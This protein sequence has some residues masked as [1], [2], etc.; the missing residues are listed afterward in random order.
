MKEEEEEKLSTRGGDG[1]RKK[2]RQGYI[3]RTGRW[4]L[5]G[6]TILKAGQKDESN[7]FLLWYELSMI[8]GVDGRCR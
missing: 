7:D 8:L 2:T 1:G 6:T 3:P 4:D 5:L